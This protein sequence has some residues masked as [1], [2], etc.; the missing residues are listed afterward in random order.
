MKALAAAN[1]KTFVV[2]FGS[3]IDATMLNNMAVSGGTT[4]NTTLL[5]RPTTR[6]R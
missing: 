1:I 2:G 4:R 6:R 3:D 5:P